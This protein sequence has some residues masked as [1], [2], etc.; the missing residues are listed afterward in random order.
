MKESTKFWNDAS[1]GGIIIGVV[2][3]LQSLTA[4]YTTNGV[5]SF[6][7]LAA[8]VAALVVLMRRRVSLYSSEESGYSYGK[9][10][11]FILFISIFAGILSG[12]YEV[13]AAN[14]FF[15]EKYSANI[16]AS[17]AILSNMNMYTT[18]Q[19][20]MMYAMAKS[21][22][23]SPIYVIL[24]QVFGMVIKGLFFGLILSAFLSRRGDI[25]ASDKAAD[26]ESDAVNEEKK[27][28]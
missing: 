15:P 21:M 13:L 25:F 8:Y 28:E 3:I 7:F 10:V 27:E 16:E 24:I 18:E 26:A 6:A 23:T 22:L 2:A 5:V 20:D 19:M 14:F 9:C 17:M 12:A 11:K 4:I 1:N